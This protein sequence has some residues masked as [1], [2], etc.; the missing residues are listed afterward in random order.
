MNRR[1]LLIALAVALPVVSFAAPKKAPIFSAKFRPIVVGKVA[2]ADSAFDATTRYLL[3]YGNKTGETLFDL[4][5]GARRPL[6]ESE[7]IA[8]NG[9][10]K[11]KLRFG[12]TVQLELRHANGPSS[13]YDCPKFE[14]DGMKPLSPDWIRIAPERNRLEALLMN[15]CYRWEL[16]SGRLISNVAMPC[17]DGSVAASSTSPDVLVKASDNGTGINFMSIGSG[18]RVRHVTLRAPS[19]FTDDQFAPGGSYAI[20]TDNNRIG[21]SERNLVVD[22]RTGRVLWK[23]ALTHWRDSSCFSPDGKR[24]AVPQ[25]K[26][27]QWEIRDSKTGVILHILPLVTDVHSAPFSPDGFT[28]YSVANGVL[29]KQRAR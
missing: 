27:Q 25:S 28:L 23:F 10:W 14:G 6:Q 3:V 15:R 20:C 2:G 5:T 1:L 11:W 4:K 17:F 26:R 12:R 29:Y 19:N 9:A 7:G 22:T 21:P 8:S 16:R 18:R 24:L 13:R